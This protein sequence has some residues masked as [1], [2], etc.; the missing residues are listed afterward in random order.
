M[1][2]SVRDLTVLLVL[3]A[4]GFAVAGCGSGIFGLA[5]PEDEKRVADD[6]AWV[7]QIAAGTAAR[8]SSS[9]NPSQ[10]G[11]SV[12]KSVARPEGD[13]VEIWKVTNDGVVENGGK[14]TTVTMG[15]ACFVTEIVTY[16]WNGG[17]GAPAGEIALQAS[18]GT[19]YGPW[20]ATARNNVYWVATPDQDV[21]AGTY[22]V[23]DSDTATWAQNS[24][25]KGLGMT[26]ASGIPIQ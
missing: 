7:E 26:W 8:K 10:E 22:T 11:D 3:L 25:T 12:M 16:H 9:Q 15:E 23:T 5:T 2:R 1:K 13:P 18:D 24:G 17:A 14:P 21:P 19:V 6:K 4:L 20:K